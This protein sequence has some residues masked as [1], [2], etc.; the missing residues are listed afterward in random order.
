MVTNLADLVSRLDPFRAMGTRLGKRL[1]QG[2]SG[3]GLEGTPPLIDH[4]PTWSMVRKIALALTLIIGSGLAAMLVVSGIADHPATA[5]RVMLARLLIAI[6]LVVSV[7]AGWLIV[8]HVNRAVEEIRK[9]TR[10]IAGG[11]LEYR[12]DEHGQDGLGLLARDFNLM[13]AH[14]ETNTVSKEELKEVLDALSKRTEELTRSNIELDRFASVVSHDLQE[15][16]RMIT[17]YVHLLQTQY[18]GKLDKDADEFIGFAVDGAKRM[19]TLINDLLAYSRLGTRGKEFAAVDC[20]MV[21]MRTLLNLK[22]SMDE[23]GARLTH[24]QLPTVV[25]DELQLGQL[26]QN[27]IGN[28]IKYHGPSPPEIHVGCERDGPVWRFAIRDNGIGIDPEYAERIFVIFQR[29]HTRQ[30]YPGTGIGLAICKKIVERHRGKI[31][32]ESVPGKG[33]TFYFTLPAVQDLRPP[34]AGS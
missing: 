8:R 27:L 14:L 13:A 10:M 1:N 2:P 26:F 34:N 7:G 18:A 16:L 20:N 28:A 3:A 31:W 19:Q 15:P 30:E 25:G 6:F 22:T 33:S 4:A 9:G 12:L 24:D 5:W 17:A 11:N 29:L 21:L 23:G 32:V